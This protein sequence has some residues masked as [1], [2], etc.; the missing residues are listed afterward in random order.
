MTLLRD[1]WIPLLAILILLVLLV[2]VL[3]LIYEQNGLF[4]PFASQPDDAE[5]TSAVCLPEKFEIIN[6]KVIPN[7]RI[8]K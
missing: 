1:V 3:V 6:N 2:A 4:L 8:L 5:T 7:W